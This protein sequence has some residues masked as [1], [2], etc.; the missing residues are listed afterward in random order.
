M[1]RFWV[2]VASRDHVLA[3]VKGGFCQLSHGRPTA[4]QQLTPGDHIVYYSP[5]ER[6]REGE[7]I[8][9]FTAAGAVLDGDM[10]RDDKNPDFQPYRRNVRYLESGVALIRPLLSKLSFT[11]EHPSWG[12]VFRR[13]SFEITAAD[14]ELIIQA[15]RT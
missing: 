4:V 13:G 1:S 2:G 14:Y 12:Q 9:A 10:Y 8:Q 15:M 6:M 3:A 5:R 7:T 11:K